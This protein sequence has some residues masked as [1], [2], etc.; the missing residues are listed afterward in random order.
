[1]LEIFMM[2][3]ILCRIQKKHK[4]EPFFLAVYFV[5]PHV[6]FVAPKDYFLPYPYDKD[7]MPKKVAGD[8]N[9]SPKKGI[10][11]VTSV[12]GEMLLE[13]ERKA[14]VAYYAS[15]SYMDAQVGKVLNRLKEEDWRTIPLLFSLLI[16]VCI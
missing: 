4:D 8:W 14:M 15:M 16:M 1:M 5:R 3:R 11:Y 10:N 12:N 7:K 6:P 13:Q 9:D 2:P